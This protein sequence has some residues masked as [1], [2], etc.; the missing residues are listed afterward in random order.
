MNTGMM[1]GWAA[2]PAAPHL[3]VAASTGGCYGWPAAAA[4]GGGGC[5]G[6]PPPLPHPRAGPDQTPPRREP[7]RSP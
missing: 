3:L 4:A 2:C 5:Y 1:C 6:R 7:C